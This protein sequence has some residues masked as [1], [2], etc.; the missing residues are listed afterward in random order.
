LGAVQLLLRD[1]VG[2]GLNVGEEMIGKCFVRALRAMM[3]CFLC[4]TAFGAL[5]AFPA[6]ARII[7]PPQILITHDLG[8]PVEERMRRIERMRA[9]GEA[10]AIPYG[11]CISAC[12]LYLG[13]PDTCV[14]P[15]A[16]F[17]F[18]GPSAGTAGLGLPPDEFYRISGAMA[19][20]YPAPVR[21]WFLTTAR[22]TKLTYLRVS[23][24]QLI[25]L[26]VKQCV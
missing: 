9:R 17:G 26:G 5:A 14:G 13:L 22:Y 10:V 24:A 18:H 1:P 3:A 4:L 25:E 21:E 2:A 15:S 12:T 8:G 7:S 11:R 20:F 19:Q 16:E 23:G 6:H